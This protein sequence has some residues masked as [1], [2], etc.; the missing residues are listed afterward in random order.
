[1]ES[2]QS[3]G[4]SVLVDIPSDEESDYSIGDISLISECESVNSGHEDDL[5]EE[6]DVD[7][8]DDQRNEEISEFSEIE[9][10]TAMETEQSETTEVETVSQS[11]PCQV[12]NTQPVASNNSATSDSFGYVMVMDNIDINVRRSFQR[13]DRTTES[14]HFCHAYAVLNRIDTSPL[15]DGPSSGVLSYKT[16]LPDACD[17]QR[18]MNDFRVL[19]SR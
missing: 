7:T 6:L 15:D 1:M 3:T 9:T 19:V 2:S 18:I 12:Q 13:I 10:N 5:D 8:E 11:V 14:F 17:L 4:Y 16:V